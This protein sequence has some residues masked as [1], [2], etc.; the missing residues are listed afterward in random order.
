[1]ATTVFNEL[2]FIGKGGHLMQEYITFPRNPLL[3]ETGLRSSV[4]YLNAEEENH[5]TNFSDL[6]VLLA[7]FFR[8]IEMDVRVQ[9]LLIANL[10]GSARTSRRS[11]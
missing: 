1:M 9:S 4:G 7:G 3:R 6:L 5:L 8:R 11:T 10:E 2:L